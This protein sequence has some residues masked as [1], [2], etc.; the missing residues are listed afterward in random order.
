MAWR[1]GCDNPSTRRVV[2]AAG[3]ALAAWLPAAAQDGPAPGVVVT[4]VASKP[5]RPAVTFTGRVEAVDYVELRAR[6]DGFLDKRSFQ[7]GAEVQQGDRLFVIEQ[8]PYQAD[9]ARAQA[10]VARAEAALKDARQQLERG[11]ELLGRR[12]IPQA[13]VDSREAVR[14]EADADLLAARAA[15]QQAQIA[16]DYT[17][18]LAPIAGRIGR[19]TYSIGNLVGPGSEV[20][21]TIVSRDPIYVT[22]PVSERQLLDMDQDPSTARVDLQT[23]RVEVRLANGAVYDQAGTVDFVDIETDQRADTTLVRASLPNPDGALRTGQL[24]EVI[25]RAAKP[26]TALVVPNPAVLIDQAGS[27]VLV[28]GQDGKVEQR[29]V[30]TQGVQ[31]SDTVVASGLQ[32]GERVITEGIQRV[33]PGQEVQA[34]E[35]KPA[36]A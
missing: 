19:S 6:V 29:R 25:V 24:V 10:Q 21:A 34:T 28:V 27:Y 8:A 2:S 15:L 18:I 30:Q 1:T 17:E 23:A 33:R 16:L 20:L 36:G 31:G 13:E 3:L 4:P 14:D 22:F 5:I 26:E 7:E 9:L 12:N 32:A 11:K 35:A